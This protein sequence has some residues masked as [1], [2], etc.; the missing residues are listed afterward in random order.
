MDKIIDFVI[1]S[2]NAGRERLKMSIVTFYISLLALYHWRVFAILFFGD[3]PMMK[4]IEKIDF[5]YKDYTP[6]FYLFNSL[7]ILLVSVTFMILFPTIMW[8]S[9]KAL[10]YVSIKRKE[11]KE[12]EEQKDRDKE[13]EI[14]KHQFKLKK[15]ETGN[16]NE[17]EYLDQIQNLNKLI[18]KHIQEK[19]EIQ[20]ELTDERDKQRIAIF[21]LKNGFE[22]VELNYK[23]Q[24]EELKRQLS[25]VNDNSNAYNG[26]LKAGKFITEEENFYIDTINYMFRK[27]REE[28]KRLIEDIINNF[29]KPE[30]VINFSR[31][32]RGYYFNNILNHLSEL[33]VIDLKENSK[34]NNV[35]VMTNTKGLRKIVL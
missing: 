11:K 32:D 34:T 30:M 20:K 29:K 15:E 35:S 3:I 10:V 9:E 16:L 18:S 22:T 24:V 2:I 13:I 26:I 14:V 23:N 12:E 25:V 1:D 4:K 33:G 21:D 8:L 28:D 27:L 6:W 17:N 5:L 19:K 31:E 7:L